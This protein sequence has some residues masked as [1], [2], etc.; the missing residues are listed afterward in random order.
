MSPKPGAQTTF[1]PFCHRR[2][3][4]VDTTNGTRMDHTRRS[5][6]KGGRCAGSERHIDTRPEAHA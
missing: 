2:R 4:V 1:C 3:I 6:R 5:G